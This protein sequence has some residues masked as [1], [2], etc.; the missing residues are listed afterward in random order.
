KE[1]RGDRIEVVNMRFPDPGEVP[2]PELPA[3][4]GLKKADYFRMA[5]IGVLAIVS[6][7][8][9]LLVARPLV[10]RLLAAAPDAASSV[11]NAVGQIAAATKTGGVITGPSSG[12]GEHPHVGQ[13]DDM[14]PSVAAAQAA[15]R[16]AGSEFEA[17][18]DLASIENQA[19]AAS[20][21]KVGE[22]VQDNPEEAVTIIRGWLH[23]G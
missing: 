10:S 12:G 18:L 16:A 1:E 11:A 7:L 2:E 17:M 14:S 9:I 22:L 20:M 8:V 5:E 3:F 23:N 4:L 13:D 21:K 19:K 15:A 6:L